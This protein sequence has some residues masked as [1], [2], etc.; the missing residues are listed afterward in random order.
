MLIKLLTL[1]TY[2]FLAGVGLKQGAIV[3]DGVREQI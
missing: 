3:Q 1:M 2:L